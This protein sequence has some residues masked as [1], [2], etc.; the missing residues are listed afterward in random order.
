MAYVI[1]EPCVGVKSADCVD[2]CPVSCI[3]EAEDMYYIHPEECIECGACEPVCP[4]SAIYHQDNVPE[5]WRSY[6][7]KNAQL[8][9]V[10]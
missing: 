4:V 8:S 5:Q 6:I 1:C 3:Y 2:V 10:S 9:G 7:E